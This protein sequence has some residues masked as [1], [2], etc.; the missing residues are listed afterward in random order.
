MFLQL[1]IRSDSYVVVPP[2]GGQTL[3]VFPS[4]TGFYR[5]V[6]R[7]NQTNNLFTM[8]EGLVYP[9]E[10]SSLHYH[11]TEDE[12]NIVVNGTLQFCVDGQQF[13][14]EAD[15]TVFVPRNVTKSVRN[16][17]SEPVHL[18]LLFSPSGRERYL[19]AADVMNRNPP[20]NAIAV[21]ELALKYG[22]VT[23][24]EVSRWKDLNCH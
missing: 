15:T 16:M 7:G 8:V 20:V 21:Q 6:L 14:A 1:V 13:C 18:R 3:Q 19:E 4:P 2:N 9:S 24:G 11:I 12:T 10:G 22:Q 23:L 17:G 5:I